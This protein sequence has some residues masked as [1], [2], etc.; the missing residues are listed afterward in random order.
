MEQGGESPE[1][2]EE[3]RFE[4]DHDMQFLTFENS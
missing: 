3:E 4:E 1:R 2:D